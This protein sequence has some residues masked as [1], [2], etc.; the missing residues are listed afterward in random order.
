[1]KKMML[2]LSPLKKLLHRNPRASSLDILLFLQQFSTLFAAGIPI[3]QCFDILEKTQSK[4]CLRR[5]LSVIKNDI[6][7]GKNLF[8]G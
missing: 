8:T 2:M 6:S 3:I 1:M 5:L 7:S 4:I